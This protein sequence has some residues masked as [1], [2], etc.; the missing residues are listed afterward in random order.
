M[1]NKSDTFPSLQPGFIAEVELKV[2]EK[3]TAAHLGSGSLD[4]YATPAMVAL[5]ENA[6][7]RAMDGQLPPGY[8]TVGGKID[9]RHLAATPVR[10]KVRAQAELVQVQ[11]RK[12]IFHIQAWDEAEQI[13]EA[14][15][16]R[17]LIDEVD[18]MVKVTEKGK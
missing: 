6:A 14:N 16:I 2:N 15:H 9:V 8:T 10:M 18:F 17:Y 3:E 7:V 4:I 12:L 11:G 1:I 13:G 5:M